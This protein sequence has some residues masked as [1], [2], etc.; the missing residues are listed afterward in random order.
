MF[1][2]R[3]LVKD[4]V[5]DGRK[6]VHLSKLADALILVIVRRLLVS[7]VL[8]ERSTL[9]LE[10]FS[11]QFVDRNALYAEGNYSSSYLNSHSVVLLQSQFVFQQNDCAE[12]R[13]V[14]FNVETISFTFNDSMAPRNTDIVNS[15]FTL[16]S[17]P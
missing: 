16:V 11:A 12:F 1:R 5:R 4:G 14:V 6:F 3:P 8:Q 10:S 2:V 9:F 13:L 17:S 7:V 15:N